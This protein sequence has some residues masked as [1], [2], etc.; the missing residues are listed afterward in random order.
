MADGSGNGLLPGAVDYEEALASAS[1]ERPDVEWS[2]DDLYVLYTGGTTGLP[3]GVLWRQGD[4]FPV[5]MGGRNMDLVGE[6]VA[7]SGRR[8]RERGE[9]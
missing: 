3:K 8:G 9:R 6:G 5:A 1:P 7:R 2:P 4:I